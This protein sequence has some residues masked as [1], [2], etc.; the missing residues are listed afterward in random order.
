WARW[1]VQQFD[2]SPLLG[3]LHRPVHVPL[4]D[5]QGKPLKRA[6]QVEALRKGWAQAVS[7]LPEDAKPTRVFYDT[8]LDREWVIPLTQALHG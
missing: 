7:A 6:G 4:T 3:Y 5:E 1:Q 8:S 2:E